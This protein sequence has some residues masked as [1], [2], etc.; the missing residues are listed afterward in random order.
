MRTLR[1]PILQVLT[2]TLLSSFVPGLAQEEYLVFRSARRGESPDQMLYK[3]LSGLVYEKLA[4]RD[5][6]EIKTPADSKR[7]GDKVRKLLEASLGPWPP[8]KTPLQAE[9]TGSFSRKRYKVERVVYQS[10]PGFY[11]TA[12]LYLPP[13]SM[14]SGPF[15]AVLGPCGHTML[16]KAFEPY[17]KVYSTLASL[18]FV[19]LTY[20]PPGQGERLMYYDADMGESL[21]GSSTV[22]HSMAG[23][24]CF[25]SG[26]NAA[27]YFIWDGIRG[28]DYLTTRPEVDSSR[29]AVTGNSGGGNLTAYLAALD[30]RLVAAAPTCY[31]TSWRAM[32]DTYGMADAEQNLLP[33]I[34][35]GFSYT[36]YVLPF[37]PKPY[38]VNAGIQ[39]FFSIRG[40]RET[41]R[42]MQAIYRVWN[43]EDKFQ[44]FESDEGHGYTKPRREAT[45]AWFGEHLAGLSGPIS[46]LDMQPE[47]TRDLWSTPTGQMSTAYADAETIGSLNARFT[48]TIRYQMR[49]LDLG[50]RLAEFAEETRQTA[51]R[52]TRFTPTEIEIDVQS[53]GFAPGVQGSGRIERLTF[54]SEPGITIPALLIRA[55]KP[56]P[57]LP[58]VLYLP[59]RNKAWDL[60]G[61]ISELAQAGFN[62]L[63]VDLRGKGETARQDVRLGAFYDW[64]SRDW[65]VTMMALQLDRP[66]VGMRTLDIVRA[67]E[68]LS[69]M[70]SGKLAASGI[71]VVGKGSACVPLLHAAILEPRIKGLILE[72]GLVSW[73]ALVSSKLHRLQFENIVP[74]ALTEYDLPL[75]AAALAPR[76]LALG[77]LADPMGHVLDPVSVEHEY[78][79]ARETYRLSGAPEHLQI[80]E[81]PQGMT[82]LAAY[83]AV[84]DQN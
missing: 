14:G 38:L 26:S 25:L 18:G 53:R 30:E 80:R 11:V 74:G 65:D 68:L 27:A 50:H 1:T 15:P 9:V 46:E 63:S 47:P 79:V 24:Q 51:L 33:I 70:E 31:I 67:V 28:I 4:E 61:D 32:W 2:M 20:D 5:A 23:I 40:A 6:I 55:E 73:Q 16:G 76:P 72:E 64:F 48:Q 69:S 75:L 13:D 78:E 81:R 22:E 66:L 39:D 10:R 19:V 12:T 36:D 62:V 44:F 29:I 7:R 83:A 35:N 8:D 37:A 42:E 84:L 77:N 43:A 54:E 41:A 82:M 45:Y 52:M 34:A 21:L 17:Q 49:P 71:V 59:H 60:T 57:R 58:V 56:D 3:Y